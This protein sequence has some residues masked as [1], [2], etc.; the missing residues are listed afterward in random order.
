MNKFTEFIN[1]ID[2]EKNKIKSFSYWGDILDYWKDGDLFQKILLLYSIIASLIVVML[3]LL[4]F[5][6]FSPFLFLTY[7][8]FNKE[9]S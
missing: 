7:L 3:G 2:K 6:I 9:R 8:L 5:L 1:V 4:I